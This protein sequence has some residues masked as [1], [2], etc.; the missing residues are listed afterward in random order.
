M[1]KLHEKKLRLGEDDVIA[2]DKYCKN[3]K[4]SFSEFARKAMR[5]FCDF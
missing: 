4:I 3:K 2:F 5:V 1:K